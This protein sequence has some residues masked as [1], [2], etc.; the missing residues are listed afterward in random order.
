[1]LLHWQWSVKI[2]RFICIQC[3]SHSFLFFFKLDLIHSPCYL[4]MS[5]FIKTFLLLN[6]WCVAFVIQMFICLV[7]FDFILALM[8]LYPCLHLQ[9]SGVFSNYYLNRLEDLSVSSFAMLVLFTLFVWGVN[10]WFIES[11][12]GVRGFFSI[13]FCMSWVIFIFMRAIVT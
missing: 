4:P 13:P 1:M 3:C 9:T 12:K 2:N 6:L 5:T 11:P 10:I 7:S 8:W